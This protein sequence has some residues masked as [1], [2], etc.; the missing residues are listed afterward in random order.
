ML[1]TVCEITHLALSA[2]PWTGRETQA[3]Q[4]PLWGAGLHRM[5]RRAGMGPALWAP[6]LGPS[7]LGLVVQVSPDSRDTRSRLLAWERQ[8]QVPE[9]GEVGGHSPARSWVPG[10]PCQSRRD[11]KPHSL[12]LTVDSQ[13]G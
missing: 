10:A 5:P 7:L 8:K 9:A 13:T 4:L 3:T 2:P 6:G 1:G 12:Q 11:S